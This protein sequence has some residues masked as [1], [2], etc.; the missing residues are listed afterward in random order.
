MTEGDDVSSI[1]VEEAVA[2]HL[3]LHPKA[4]SEEI[5]AQLGIC[6]RTVRKSKAWARRHEMASGYRATATAEYPHKHVDAARVDWREWVQWAE[7][8]VML[9]RQAEPT[10][11]VL[12]WMAPRP[13]P[14]ALSFLGDVHAFSYWSDHARFAEDIKAILESPSSF[15]FVCGDLIQ[16]MLN[17]FP[18]AAAVAEQM[19]PPRIQARIAEAILEELAPKVVGFHLGNHEGFME[20][21]AG[22]NFVAELARRFVPVFEGKGLTM[23]KVGNAEYSVLSM[24]KGQGRSRFSRT[25]QARNAYGSDYPADLIVGAHTHAFGMQWD[26]AYTLAREA[27]QT[28]GGER[29]EVNLGTYQTGVSAYSARLGGSAGKYALPTVVLMPGQR[30][31]V[32][33]RHLA[34]ALVYLRGLTGD[35]KGDRDAC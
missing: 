20:K 18:S 15:V 10:D 30:Q 34:H 22:L 27:G 35:L 1:Q 13:E 33:F 31:M 14:I 21:V 16:G 2:S 17:G 26:D 4:D 12:R 29:L 7:R 23:L 24:H 9:Q 3:G 6:G 8:G 19:A 5:G 32:P 11:R 28:F 25:A